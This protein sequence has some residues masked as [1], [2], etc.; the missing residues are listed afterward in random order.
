MPREF[1]M[2][3]L[4]RVLVTLVSLA[5]ASGWASPGSFDESTQE[6]VLDA[7]DVVEG[8]IV[9]ETVSLRMALTSAVFPLQLQVTASQEVVKQGGNKAVWNQDTGVLS[10]PG[11]TD[12]RDYFVLEMNENVGSEPTSFTVTVAERIQ[13]LGGYGFNRIATFPVYLNTDINNETVAEILDVSEDGMTVIYTDSQL[14]ALGFIDISNPGD[15]QPLGTVDLAGEPTSVG[16]A[17]DY[18]LAAI[19]TSPSLTAPSGELQI[20]DIASQ[21]IVRSMDLGGQPDAVAI[22]PDGQ[23]AAIAIENERDEDLGDGR[24]PQLP[25][26]FLVIIDLTGGPADWGMRTIGLDGIPDL[27]PEDPEP[28]FVDINADNRVVISLQENNYLIQV[29]LP[30]G[31]IVAD[32]SAG[33]VNLTQVDAT[34]EDP[35][36]IS[37][38]ETLLDVPREPDGITWIGNTMIATANEGDMD[39]GSRGF[40]VFDTDGNVIYDSGNSLDHAAV[41]VGHY[42]DARS[43]NKGNEPENIEYG[44]FNGEQYLFVNSE[45]SSIIFVYN[46][47]NLDF[48]I[49]PA[50][51]LGPEGSKVIPERNL[52]VVATEEDARDDKFRGTV[53]IY[54]LQSG[55]PVYPGIQSVNRLDGTPIPW[56][57]LS[58]LAADRIY[59]ELAYTI[60]DSFY[61][62]SRLFTLDISDHP[63]RIAQETVLL[64]SSGLLAAVEPDLV[65]MDNTVNLDLEGISTSADGG[66]WLASEG[67]GT[68]GD[69]ERPVTSLNLV[70]HVSAAGEIDDVV[71]LLGDTNGRQVRFGFEGIAATGESG[72]EILYVAFQREWAD[73]PDGQVRIGRY[74]TASSEWTF[75]YYPLDAVE[76]PAGGW[77][78]LSDITAISPSEFAVVERDNQGATDGRIKR[79]YRFSVDSL[80][81][82]G[83]LAVGN[84]PSFPVVEKMFVRDLIPDILSRGGL[85]LEKIEGMALTVDGKLLFNNDNDGVDDNNG[86]SQLFIID[87][88]I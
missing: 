14:E 45:R 81:P 18:A 56:G 74:D 40:S 27:F 8:G 75:Y 82:T 84:T 43:G 66:F 9:T 86:E 54:Q 58:G 35:A 62:Q 7:V 73:D 64:D 24:P 80:T 13:G 5:M 20:V 16:V 10:V 69:P 21:S 67:A 4:A 30:S 83:E 36:L 79:I 55:E 87:S 37:L 42:P 23:Y 47:E 34:E 17:G 19:N 38:T 12:G 71:T 25:S 52:F 85:I 22:S 32:W 6:L 15:P 3:F 50:G 65:N 78:G 68:I 39:G 77:V 41:R 2:I 63:A 44:V 59:P 46:L 51:S 29:D 88:P 1:K 53:T 72:S 31:N 28:E 60:P 48:Q 61:Q 70:L 11:A 33:T 26:G 76:S 57:A 49:L